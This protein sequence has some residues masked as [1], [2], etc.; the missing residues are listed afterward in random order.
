MYYWNI[1]GGGVVCFFFLFMS[2]VRPSLNVTFPED[3]EDRSKV[4][5]DISLYL[6]LDYHGHSSSY[7][8]ELS[9]RHLRDS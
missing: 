6:Y 4:S 5:R 2:C 9:V 8:G 7:G 3:S 1:V